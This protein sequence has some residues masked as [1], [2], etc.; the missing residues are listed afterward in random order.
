MKK[1]VL[2]T[3]AIFNLLL[4]IPAYNLLSFP[5]E[6][7][8][9]NFESMFNKSIQYIIDE[10][11]TKAITGFEKLDSIDNKNYL[12]KITNKYSISRKNFILKLLENIPTNSLQPWN[13]LPA[14]KKG[15]G[16]SNWIFRES[17]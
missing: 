13:L 14:F 1:V 11:Y 6:N 12:A 10:N 4:F 3:A 9:I 5:A 16:K 2:C 7:P 17:Y 8:T 15:F